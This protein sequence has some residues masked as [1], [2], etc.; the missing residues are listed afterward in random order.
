[1]SMKFVTNKIF[2]IYFILNKSKFNKNRFIVKFTIY[3]YLIFY[4]I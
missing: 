4:N 3:H 1:M 2:K